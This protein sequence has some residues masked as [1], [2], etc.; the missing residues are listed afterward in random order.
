MSLEITRVPG[1]LVV[2]AA[3]E[4]GATERVL[5]R[6]IDMSFVHEDVVIILPV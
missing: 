6:D 5:W 2:M 1:G 4:D 3:G